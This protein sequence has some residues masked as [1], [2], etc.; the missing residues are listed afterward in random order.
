MTV[1]CVLQVGMRG[2]ETH[3]ALCNW[4]KGRSIYVIYEDKKVGMR[5]HY[6]SNKNCLMPALL[7]DMVWRSPFISHIF[8]PIYSV[9]I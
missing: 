3:L 4:W 8:Y 5:L 6:L 7:P 9:L 1:G 2:S